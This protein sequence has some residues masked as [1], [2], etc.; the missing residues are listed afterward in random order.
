MLYKHVICSCARMEEESI[1]EWVE[2][3]RS[4]GFEHFYIYGNDD[5]YSILLETLASLISARIVTYTHCPE[6][7]AQLRMYRHFLEKYSHLSEWICFLDQDEFVRLDGF[8]DDV[9]QLT[10]LAGKKFDSVQ[11]HWLNYG[12]SGF[13]DRPKG[14][15]LKKYTH[16]SRLIHSH[17]KHISRQKNYY[18]PNCLSVPWWHHGFPVDEIKTCSSLLDPAIGFKNFLGSPP[19]KAAFSEYIKDNS[20][21]FIAHATIAHFHLKSENDFQR[22]LA[23]SVE[24]DFANQD[25]YRRLLASDELKQAHINSSNETRDFYLSDYWTKYLDGL[26]LGNVSWY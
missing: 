10:S 14:S 18:V 19:E 2:Y 6:K 8:C 15:V 17:T 11:L 26:T 9:W 22:R 20:D 7:G 25:F 21:L 5:D 16:R 24:K 3:H 12:T 4:I 1:L 13:V 23:R